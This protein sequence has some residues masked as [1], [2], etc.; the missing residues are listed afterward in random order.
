MVFE[1]GI[2][3]GIGVG[4]LLGRLF[5]G[6]LNLWHLLEAFRS[7]LVSV[8]IIRQ[9]LICVP[10][11][12]CTCRVTRKRWYTINIAIHQRTSLP[13]TIEGWIGKCFF[14]VLR[15]IMS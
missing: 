11:T 14:F 5:L 3:V 4:M 8:E 2:H 13:G 7:C 12:T 1:Y 9:A 15:S 10:T 6:I